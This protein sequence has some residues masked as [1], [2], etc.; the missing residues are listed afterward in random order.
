MKTLT[1]DRIEWSYTDQ[2][3]SYR[4]TAMKAKNGTLTATIQIKGRTDDKLPF[5]RELAYHL[6]THMLRL[7]NRLIVGDERDAGKRH[8]D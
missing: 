5:E 7:M 1:K 4:V 6:G 3:T 2:D 8:Q